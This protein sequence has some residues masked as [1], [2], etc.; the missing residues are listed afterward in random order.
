MFGLFKPHKPL[1]LL[2]ENTEDLKTL[3]ALTQDAALKVGNILYDPK[4]RSLT[5]A[6]S[7]YCHE[8]KKPLRV[9]AA[10]RFDGVLAVKSRGFAAS[11]K[12]KSLSLLDID[13][14]ALD[15]PAADI[16]LRFAGHETD[17]C[18]H[19]EAIDA[20]LVDLDAP[21]RAKSSPHHE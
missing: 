15:A 20:L 19:V 13:C 9:D 12:T 18:L 14:V 7:R 17:L 8:V 11:D 16:T 21:R 3:A 2:C 4:T 10:L 6:I 1:K 5:L